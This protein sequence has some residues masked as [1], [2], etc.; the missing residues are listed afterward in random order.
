MSIWHDKLKSSGKKLLVISGGQRGVDQAGLAAAVDMGLPTGGWAPHGWK[1][2]NGSMPS[3]SKLGL[4]EHKSDKYPP[5]T[6]SNVKDSD[7]TIRLAHDF[8]TPGERCTKKAIDFYSKPHYDI[9]L[10][11]PDFIFDVIDWIDDNNIKVLNV[12]GNAGKL[13]IEGTK[14]FISARKYLSCVF[15]AYKD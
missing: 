1:T 10:K 12:A 8:T 3:L 14:I 11:D 4:I 7:G 2:L 9:D 6:Y 5:R 13:K 15:R